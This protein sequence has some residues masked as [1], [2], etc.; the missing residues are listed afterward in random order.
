VF[1]QCCSAAVIVSNSR[2]VGEGWPLSDSWPLGDKYVIL[3]DEW[4]SIDTLKECP[5]LQ[6]LTGNA[7]THRLAGNL[8]YTLISGFSARTGA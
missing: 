2:N 7:P 6:D 4:M 1:V 5:R 3:Q 8:P